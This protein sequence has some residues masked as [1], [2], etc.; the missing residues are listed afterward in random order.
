MKLFKNKVNN[1]TKLSDKYIIVSF[2]VRNGLIYDCADIEYKKNEEKLKKD[3][4]TVFSLEDGM[5]L[6]I[7][8]NRALYEPF[9]IDKDDS[10]KLHKLFETLGG[11]KSDL[12]L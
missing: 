1:F 11:A 7:K 3:G 4:A 12:Y 2:L 10:K 9:Y 5:R 6:V 8:S